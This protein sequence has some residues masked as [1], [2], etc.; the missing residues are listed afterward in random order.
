VMTC[1]SGHLTEARFDPEYEQ[2]WQYPPPESLFGAP[3][4]VKVDRVC[5]SPY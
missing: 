3:V 4:R 5:A 1:V 2:D